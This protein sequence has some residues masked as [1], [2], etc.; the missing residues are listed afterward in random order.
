[1]FGSDLQQGLMKAIPFTAQ[2]LAANRTGTITEAQR[3]RLGKQAGVT[4]VATLVMFVIFILVFAAIGA[5]LFVFSNN[6]QSLLKMFSHDSTTLAIVAGVMAAVV[7]V[8]FFSF[9]R[10]LRRTTDVAR[11]KVSVTEGPLKVK[12]VNSVAYT[13][14]SYQIK[15]G[16]VQFY[17]NEAVFSSLVE[18]SNY[19]FY[20]IK[21][22]PIQTIL[23][24]EQ[25]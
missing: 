1:M 21:N 8:I 19:R 25:I 23:S 5:Y 22:P 20:Y 2:D 7:L 14:K 6:G 24:V 3:A 16:K 12:S 10:T 4:R 18:G 17:I 11:G 9:L 15:V 13:V